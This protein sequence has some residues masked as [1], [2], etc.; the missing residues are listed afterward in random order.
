MVVPYKSLTATFNEMLD[1]EGI[2]GTMSADTQDVRG[3]PGVHRKAQAGV[4]GLLT[5]SLHLMQRLDER[6]DARLVRAQAGWKVERDGG[7]DAA[8]ALLQLRY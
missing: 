2:A 8:A 7:E 4:Q 3:H 5:R 1:Y 6:A